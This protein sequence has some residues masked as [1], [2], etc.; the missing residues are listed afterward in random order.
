MLPWIGAVAAAGLILLGLTGAQAGGL[1]TRAAPVLGFLVGASVLAELADRAQVFDVAA[2]RAARLAGGSV[3]R[4]YAAVVALAIG[5]TVLLGLDTTAVLL[6]PAVLSLCDQTRLR[7]WP[8]ALAVVWLANTASLL[9]PVSNL[10]NLLA[11]QR[12][13]DSAVQYAVGVVRPAAVAVL[14]TVAVLVV[15]HGRELT[16]RYARPGP[17]QVRDPLLLGIAAGCCTALAPLVLAGVPPWAAA[18]TGALVV[19]AA[20]HRRGGLPTGLVPWRTATAVLLALL[21]VAALGPPL[22]ERLLP[23]GL[24]GDRQVAVVAAATANLVNNLP[25]Y[26]LLEPLV[27]TTDSAALLVGVDLAPLVTPWA[28]VATLLWA[29]RCRAR[30]VPVPWPRFVLSGGL[31]VP[32]L[33]LATVPVL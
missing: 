8:F 21:V 19:A 26:L 33:L 31:L 17:V 13:G 12:S 6:T 30:G 16:G 9:L 7:P 5:C 20:S 22:L 4:L 11:T 27:P 2:Y 10:T 32:L 24:E 1:L 3:R 25:A 29:Q 28:S 18:A 14:V 15:L 23:G